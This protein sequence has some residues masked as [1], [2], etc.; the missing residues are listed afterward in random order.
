MILFYQKPEFLQKFIQLIRDCDQKILEIYKKDFTIE[1]KKD[2]SPL[3]IADKISNKHIC[4]FLQELNIELEQETNEKFLIISEENKTID[5]EIR[6]NYNYC[7]LVDPIDGTKEF[8]KKNGEFTVNIGLIYNRIPIFGIVSIPV[9]NIIYY[10]IEGVGSYKLLDNNDKIK[11]IIIK[12]KM[13]DN[14]IKIVAS[15]SHLNEDTKK[16]INSYSNYELISIGSSIKLLF[17]ADNQAHIYPR[18][19]P[20]YEWDTCASHAVVKYAGGNVYEFNKIN[21]LV[22]NKENLLNPYFI[23]Q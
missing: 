23:A 1:Y 6:K 3:T 18:V 7:W 10:G 15:K 16:F 2:E 19:A 4:N 9:Q 8:I 12:N 11:L 22:Y 17:I 21:E 13:N 20:T 5:Y 14:I